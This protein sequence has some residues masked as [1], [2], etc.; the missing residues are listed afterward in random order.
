MKTIC[1]YNFPDATLVEWIIED[2][3]TAAKW[4]EGPWVSEPMR[5]V[6]EAFGYTCIMARGP[7]GAWCGYVEVEKP[8]PWWGGRGDDWQ[9]EAHGGITWSGEWKDGN[10]LWRFG[11]DCAHSG[12]LT[13][14]DG[15]KSK[16][17]LFKDYAYRD[18]AYVAAEVEAL[19][20]QVDAAA[21]FHYE[22]EILY[23]TTG[24]S[25]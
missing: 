22:A 25:R 24:A 11:F 9:L 4:G 8:H 21:P 16:S 19:A 6:W 1:G 18:V 23:V 14:R 2:Y 17:S 5:I 20:K 12:D 10:G 13:P 15:A 3:G 7:S